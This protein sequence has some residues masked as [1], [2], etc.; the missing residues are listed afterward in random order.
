MCICS[1]DGLIV[2]LQAVAQLGH[3]EHRKALLAWLV[4]LT[5]H[6]QDHVTG[7]IITGLT[8]YLHSWRWVA[9]LT[10]HLRFNKLCN[11]ACSALYALPWNL[12]HHSLAISCLV[13]LLVSCKQGL[14]SLTLK[15]TS[16]LYS[17]GVTQHALC[18]AVSQVRVNTMQHISRL[19][20]PLASAAACVDEPI[21]AGCKPPDRSCCPIASA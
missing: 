10:Q 15:H 21:Q 16:A 11:Y 19:E 13:V 18:T 17:Y 3:S 7:G 4:C 1:T 20:Q 6:E 9:D 8:H 12:R 5:C 14:S 2:L